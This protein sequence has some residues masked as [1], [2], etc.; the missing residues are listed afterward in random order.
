MTFKVFLPKSL[1]NWLRR[2]I[3]TGAFKHP[4][5]AALVAFKDLQELDCHPEVRKK[6]L[7]AMIRDAID[8][9]RPGI[10]IEKVRADHYARLRQY[11][12]TKPPRPKPLPK[13]RK[14]LQSKRRGGQK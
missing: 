1:A 5:E 10:P 12:S 13:R 4:A 11:A 3:R 8:D 7:Q 9:P 6:L 2:K 14:R